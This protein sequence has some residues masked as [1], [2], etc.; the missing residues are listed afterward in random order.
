MI[1]S[2]LKEVENTCGSE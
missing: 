1:T 2:N